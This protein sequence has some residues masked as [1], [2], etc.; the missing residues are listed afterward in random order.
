[1]SAT[2]PRPTGSLSA[3]TVGVENILRERATSAIRAAEAESDQNGQ[4]AASLRGKARAYAEAADLVVRLEQG[5]LLKAHRY[6]RS[7]S[8]L[9]I[10]P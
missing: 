1:V 9:D 8:S 4:M 10:R 7:R 5:R 6:Y 3:R 2:Y